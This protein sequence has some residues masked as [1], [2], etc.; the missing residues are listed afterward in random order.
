MCNAIFYNN[1]LI[2]RALIGS[3]LSSIRVQTDKILIY[4]RELSSST[5]GSQT[6]NFLTNEILWTFLSSQSKSEKSYWQCCVIL[7]KIHLSLFTATLRP[8]FPLFIPGIWPFWGLVIV[9]NKLTSVFYASVLLLMIHFVIT[10]SKFTAARGFTA[11]LTMLW[12]NLSSIRGQTHKKLTSIW[13]L[14]TVP[15]FVSAPTFCAS[16]KP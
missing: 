15:T 8:L 7:N 6:V 5:I 16:R 11:T 4:T 14:R 9:K 3:F 12:R 1:C 13:P 2:S 10:S